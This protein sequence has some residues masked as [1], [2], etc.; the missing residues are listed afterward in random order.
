MIFEAKAIL[1]AASLAYAS[2]QDV[3]TREIEDKVW[4]VT[5]AIGAALTVYEI[6]VTPGYPVL[7]AG[8]SILLTTLLAFGIYYIGL[9]GGADAKALT[10]IAVTMPIAPGSLGFISPFMPFTILG[11][12][13]ILSLILIPVCAISNLIWR[14]SGKSLFNGVKATTVQ[15]IAALFTGLKVNAETAK[16]VH[17]NL[18]EKIADGGEHYLKL[19]TRVTDD[20]DVK[21]IDYKRGY[22]WVTPAIPM[23]IFFLAGYLLSLA[24]YDIIF[25]IVAFFM[26][27]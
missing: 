5:G 12:S 8:F 19:F 24:G 2:Y 17:F 22:V 25:R 13:L 6:V 20:D 27:S 26:G 14:I 1:I 15:K 9:Y 11:N 7:L 3:K 16:S 4:L 21:V 18:M 23:I 10:A